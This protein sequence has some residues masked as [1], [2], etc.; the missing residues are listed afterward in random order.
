MVFKQKIAI[1]IFFI[2]SVFFMSLPVIRS[3]LT[4]EYGIGF[5]GPNGHDMV[6]H[7]SL[8][9][10]IKNPLRIPLPTFSGELLKNYHPFYNILVSF[11]SKITGISPSVWLFQLMPILM[12]LLLLYLSYLLGKKITGKI[13]GGLILVF[14]NTFANSFGWIIT[15]IRSGTWGGESL[16]W[17]MQS[18]ST[19]INPPY[20]LSLIFLLILILIIYHHPHQKKYTK[21]EI[22]AIILVLILCPITKSY[23]AVPIYGLFTFH[24]LAALKKRNFQPLQILSA[25]LVLAI[26]I[27]FQYNKS[28]GSLFIYKPFWFVN[29]MIESKDRLYIPILANMRYTLEAANNIGPR[30]IT[31][32]VITFFLF[33]IG[34]FSWRLIGFLSL[35]SHQNKIISL[36][37]FILILI[38][39]FF[40]Q[41]GTSWNT[42]QFLYYALFLSNILL[43]T[44]LGNNLQKPTVKILLAI[45]IVTSLLSNISFLQ[46]Y[47]GNPSPTAISKTEIEAIN[48][49]QKL[50]TGTILTYPYDEYLKTS[51]PS[52]PLPIYLYETTSYLTAY[53]KHQTFVDDYMNL[54]NS[55]YNW[56]ERLDNSKKF[57]EQKS[58]HQ[59]RGFLVNNQI[60]YIYLATPQ[61]NMIN[62]NV[63]QLYL[64]T[65]Y[66]NSEI[67]IY[68][69]ER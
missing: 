62:L 23:S 44:F 20:S 59:D 19:Q 15:L 38:P 18:A 51:H 1:I 52:T 60:D 69:V 17:A 8:I 49:L 27:F 21:K 30:L 34:N 45:I 12:S 2:A 68:Q 28:A 67:T 16:F 5:W 55:G 46:N 4:Y 39:T 56:I 11:L 9:N 25:S 47:L 32:Y 50:P 63:D 24:S 66:E 35:K 65:I 6:W 29:S 57:F 10:H 26:I 7:L 31:V 43:V 33:L 53:T 64:K 54:Q 58:I 14:L 3:G 40:I 61:K 48:F 42:I 22:I 37:I 41:K 13:S 36:I